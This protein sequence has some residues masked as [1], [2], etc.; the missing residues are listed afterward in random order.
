MTEFAVSVHN[1]GKCYRLYPDSGSRVVEWITGG[2]VRRHQEKWALRG[3]S[4]DLPRGS[5]LGVI[6]GNGAGKSTLLKILTGTTPPTTGTFSINGR[7]GSLLELGAGFHPDF[8]GKDNIYM[9]AAMLGVPKSEVKKRYDEL[10]EFAELGDYLMRP[11]RTYSSGMAMRLGFTV[12]MMSKPDI[13]ILDE[14]LAVGDQYFQKKCM[15]RIREI[16]ERGTTILFVSHSLYHVR[17][18]CDRAIWIHEGAPVMYGNPTEV[19]DEYVNFQYALSGGQAA[20]AEKVT[21]HGS[22]KDLPH[23]GDVR[24]TRKGDPTPR[25]QFD[26]GDVME[27][28]IDWHDPKQTGGWHVGFIVYRNDDVM[29]FGARTFDALPLL[30]GKGGSVVATVPVGMLAGEYF[31]SGFMLDDTC[32]HIIDQRLSW[33]RF[34]VAFPGIEKGVYQ[35]PVTWRMVGREP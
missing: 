33:A 16:R 28:T 15:D 1:L 13:L 8:N 20:L 35:P 21:G 32:E 11:V 27:I 24:L 10:S 22:L 30:S 4:F 34:K 5:A 2:R 31:V 3:I 14:I 23:L 29:L 6:G 12:A 7:L 18:M 17:Q 19:S 9:N 25:T 26:H